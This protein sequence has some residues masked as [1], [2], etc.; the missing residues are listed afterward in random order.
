MANQ[1]H[2]RPTKQAGQPYDIAKVSALP[3]A[4]ICPR[5]GASSDSIF[6]FVTHCRKCFN[7]LSL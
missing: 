5:W 1:R 6:R 7:L 3:S 2:Y 4:Q